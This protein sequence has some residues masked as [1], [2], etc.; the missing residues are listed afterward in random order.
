MSYGFGDV[1]RKRRQKDDGKPAAWN[2]GI[3]QEVL[4]DHLQVRGTGSV[5]RVL[6][7]HD[8]TYQPGDT[9]AVIRAPFGN[10]AV[11]RISGTDPTPLPLT[12]VVT[13]SASG[14]VNLSTSIGAVASKT[15]VSVT[16]GDTV[17]LL[18]RD[19]P[20]GPVPLVL[21]KALTTTSPPPAP[22]IPEPT[23]PIPDGPPPPP[24]HSASGT[25]HFSAVW[26]GSFR[27]G[28][29]RTDS[30]VVAQADWGGYG[31]NYGSWFY[32]GGPRA[33]LAGAT[34]TGCRIQ[35]RR[36]AGGNSAPQTVQLWRHGH[37][38]RPA[39]DVTRIADGPY[40]GTVAIGQTTWIAL[41]AAWGQ[42]LV[43]T[44]HGFSISGPDY[45]VLDGIDAF[46]ESG[47]VALDWTRPA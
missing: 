25:S 12:G 20:D 27:G 8:T 10:V 46:R 5:E 39:G 33:E 1:E 2:L 4:P 44:P 45:V 47:M 36:R 7:D 38:T 26:A 40:P 41:P 17:E 14:V 15:L 37:D 32:G 34:I 3:V 19:S 23:P 29:W 18:W 35:I 6:R 43:D 28:K 22:V 16:V 21:G 9:V 42:V 31:I 13:S 11:A 30:G 24:S